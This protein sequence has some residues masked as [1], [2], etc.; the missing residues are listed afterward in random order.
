MRP[1]SIKILSK[2][3]KEL[4]KK[5]S[6]KLNKQEKIAENLRVKHKKLLHQLSFSK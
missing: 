4:L 6:Y 5:E 2:Q 3:E 1:P